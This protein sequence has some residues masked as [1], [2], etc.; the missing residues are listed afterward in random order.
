MNFS[1]KKAVSPLIATVLLIVVAVVLTVIVL[2]WSRTM[3]K[4]NLDRGNDIVDWDCANAAIS[5]SNCKIDGNNVSFYVKNIGQYTL[6]TSDELLTTLIPSAGTMDS[7]LSTALAT[8]LTPGETLKV[9]ETGVN[10][11]AADPTITYVDVM[12]R[13]KNCTE[14]STAAYNCHR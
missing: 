13:S 12:V 14:V 7:D 1:N 4:T 11:Y 3:V 9:T 5:V 2:A 6:P 10:F 8:T